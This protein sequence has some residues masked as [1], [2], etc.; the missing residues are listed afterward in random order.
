MLKTEKVIKL[1]VTVGS[2]DN[3]TEEIIRKSKDGCGGYVCMANV[4]MVTT[5]TRDPKLHKIMETSLLVP[6]DGLPLVWVLKCNGFKDASRVTGMDLTVRLCEVAQNNK[7][8]V[9]FYGSMS[10]TIHGLKNFIKKNFPNLQA[11]Y[12]SPPF[13]PLQPEVDQVVVER[14]NKSGARIV[15]VG[16]GCPKQEFWMSAYTSYLPAILIGVGAAFDFMAGT[17]N[18]APLWMQKCGLEWL[19]RLVTEPQKTWK[20]YATTNPLFIWMVVREYVKR[21]ARGAK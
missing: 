6:A 5:A 11:I 3:I 20:R 8:P 12:E 17:V 10:Q 4:H 16:L 21:M 9:Y 1:P 2:L 15:F 19:H 13:L 7:L 18:R 14:I